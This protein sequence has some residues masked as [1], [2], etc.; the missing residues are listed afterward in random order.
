MQR[1]EQG[2]RSKLMSDLM[3][4]DK[5]EIVSHTNTRHVGKRGRITSFGSGVEPITQSGNLPPTETELRYNVKLDG[6]PEL[7]NLREAQIRKL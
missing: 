6:G 2:L 1:T 7:F 3:L 4:G 5:I